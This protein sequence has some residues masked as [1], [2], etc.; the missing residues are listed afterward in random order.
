MARNRR[1]GKRGKWVGR[2]LVALLAVPALYLCAALAGSLI[3]VN[4]GWVE[5]A[6]GTTIYLADNG[7]HVDIMMPIAAQGLDWRPLIPARD[8]A[9]VD[10]NSGFI[11]FGAGE[12]RVYLDTPT[13]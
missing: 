11:A 9:A 2:A 4:R 8:F 12:Q 1:K 5:P 10:P 7:I 13:W 3:P 6:H